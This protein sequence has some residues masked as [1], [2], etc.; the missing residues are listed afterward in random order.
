[1]DYIRYYAAVY[2]LMFAPGAVLYWF[3][4]HPFIRFWRRVGPRLTLLIHYSGVMV[5]AFG[6]FLFRKPLL[7]VEFGT[8]PLLIA[9]AVPL[10][11]VALVLRVQISRHLNKRILTGLPELAPDRHSTPLLTEGFYARVRHPRYLQVM[12]TFLAWALLAN[13][14]ATYLIFAASVVLLRIIIWLEERELR[15]RF[16]SV[17]DEYCTRVPRL[18]PRLS[19]RN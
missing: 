9:L 10:L 2:L 13:Y 6:L 16:G 19:A 4:I 11:A 12:L 17:Y 7:S 14:L 8:H 15:A 5:L 3:S 1:M 18:I